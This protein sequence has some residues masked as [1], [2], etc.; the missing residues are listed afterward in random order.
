MIK[1]VI[2]CICLLLVLDYGCY[3]VD[4]A[5]SVKG[6]LS[7]ANDAFGLQLI[8]TIVQDKEAVAGAVGENVFISPF[9]ISSALG[10]VMAGA[11]GQ[12]YAN[13]HTLLG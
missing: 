12:T 6:Q 10:M 4:D 9:S 8:R 2:C 1:V 7:T 5:Q 11:A 13:L 3:A